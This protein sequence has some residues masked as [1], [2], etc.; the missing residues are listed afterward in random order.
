MAS[1]MITVHNCLIRGINSIYLQ[2]INVE[3][4]SVAL[5]A[6]IKYASAWSQIL[7]SHH[8]TEEQWIFPEIEAITGEKGVM[9]VNVEQH[10]S[11]EEGL[12][13]YTAYLKNTETGREKYDG[14]KLKKLIDTFMPILRQHLLDEI[15]TLKAFDEYK[16]KTDWAKWTKDTSEKVVKAS[17]SAEGMVS[18]LYFIPLHPSF[19]ASQANA[20]LCNATT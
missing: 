11:F 5:P 20:V 18:L 15:F 8:T 6:F 3:R 1:E 14:A 19:L 13:E 2:C 7:H 16:E 12:K 4:S 17:Q 10:R 9:D